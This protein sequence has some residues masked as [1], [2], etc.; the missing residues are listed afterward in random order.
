MGMKSSSCNVAVV[1]A[2]VVG[3]FTA[4]Q[5]ASSGLHVEVYE[6]NRPGS[7]ASTANANVIHL[8]QPPPGRLR[9]RLA[10]EGSK[11]HRKYSKDLGYRLK[12]TSLVLAAT[13][14][15]EKVALKLLSP[16]IRRLYGVKP[17][18]I[19]GDRARSLEP[20]LSDKVVSAAIVEGY[21][22]VDSKEVINMLVKRLSEM[23]V[24]IVRE[25]VTSFGRGPYLVLESGVKVR[26]HFIVNSAGEEA[27]RL[28]STLGEN[29]R[30]SLVPGV[31]AVYKEPRVRSIVARPP[32]SLKPESKGGGVIPQLDGT[33]L[34]GPTYGQLGS[35][36]SLG[37]KF[38]DLLNGRPRGLQAIIRGLRTVSSKRDF[39]IAFST[40]ESRILNL[41]GI[42]SPGLTA[43]PAIGHVVSRLIGSRF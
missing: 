37:E 24:T 38:M 6:K 5:L 34:L 1:G 39:H 28:A 36:E 22:I 3:L 12:E 21:G 42:E 7:G 16:T 17:Q 13:S 40:Q 15:R 14:I 32:L 19:S 10:L 18:V 8:L 23:G 11:L 29:F 35:L 25:R 30:V 27:A 33:T 2:G 9:R 31:M 43:A 41:I 20:A 4:L 26:Y